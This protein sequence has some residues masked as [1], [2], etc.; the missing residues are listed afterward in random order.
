MKGILSLILVLSPVLSAW[1]NPPEQTGYSPYLV[2]GP[3]AIVYQLNGPWENLVPITLSADGN[4]ILAYPAP[5]D[6]K[7]MRAPIKLNKGWWLDTRGI[8]PNTAFLDYTLDAYTALK[9]I[10]SL[11]TLQ[12]HI[13]VKKPFKKMYNCGVLV[14]GNESITQL[15]KQVRSNKVKQCTCISLPSTSSG[16]Y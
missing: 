8:S 14:S 15:N 3:N 10:P 9:E 2:P 12:Q 6:V 4:N 13:R 5:A 16:N 1:M 7:N 11:A